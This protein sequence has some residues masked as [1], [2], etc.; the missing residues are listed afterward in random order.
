MSCRALLCVVAAFATLP[1]WAGT[2]VEQSVQ[3]QL[4]NESADSKYSW[5]IEG[6]QFNLKIVSADRETVYLFNGK[7]LYVCSKLDTKQLALLD[8]N[9]VKRPELVEKLKKGACQVAQSNFMA[10]FFLAPM[11][12]VESIDQSDG[13]LV[14]L[15]VNDYDVKTSKA[16]ATHAGQG[17]KNRTRSFAIVKKKDGDEIVTKVDEEFCEGDQTWRKGLYTEVVKSVMRQPGGKSLIKTLKQDYEGMPGLPLSNSSTF[18]ISDGK[19]TLKGKVK[20]TTKSV[21]TAAIDKRLFKTPEGYSVFSPE[22]IELADNSKASPSGAAAAKKDDDVGG[23]IQSLVFC[24][25][26]GALGC[27]N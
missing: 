15:S 12:A 25:I 21:K 26:A 22:S 16:A 14:T 6:D 9:K 27:F 10:R 24:A 13:L 4:G 17:C 2:I 18:T 20:L 5:S 19:S 1:A 11:S 8:K 3:T 23:F 7:N